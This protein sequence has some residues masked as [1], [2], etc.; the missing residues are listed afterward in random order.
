MLI[1]SFPHQDHKEALRLVLEYTPEIPCWPQLP[2]RGEGMLVQ[3]SRGL[4][5]WQ[6][7][8]LKIDPESPG[9][10]EEKLRFYEEYLAVTEAGVPL[11]ETRF[12]LSL[13]EAPGLYLLVEKARERAP[14]LAVKGQ[15][16]GPFT[17]ATGLRFSDGRAL[18]Y[19]P[20]MR[21]MVVRLIALKA[22]FQVELL[23]RLSSR[24][25]LFLDEPALSGFGSSAFVGVSKE[26]VIEAL[27]E[28]A[29]EIH[30]A[31]GLV[32]V[33]VCGNTD[34]S[35]L[36]ESPIEI[37]NFD[38]YDFSEKFIS[39]NKYLNEFFKRGGWVAWG[40]VPT[41]RREA[42]EGETSQGLLERFVNLL[43]LLAEQTGY[44]LAF[45]YQHSL[46]TPSCGMGTLTPALTLKSLTLLRDLTEGLNRLELLKS[47]KFGR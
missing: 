25:I 47:K 40:L 7:E 6:A 2:A 14:F 22:R 44:S 31:G 8:A 42:L 38:A 41:L 18:F 3:F 17:L 20:E 19:D 43:N 34:W 35:L 29:A 5:G 36:F 10:E 37:I 23:R 28:V 4:P 16:T 39:Y 21:D 1:G 11:G 45:L 46:L 26:E 24:V 27:S 12:V 30:R 9:F 15:I 32:G 33:H 13:E